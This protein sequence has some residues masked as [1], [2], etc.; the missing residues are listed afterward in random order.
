[1]LSPGGDGRARNVGQLGSG[2]LTTDPDG[3]ADDANA[4]FQIP[5]CIDLHRGVRGI[6][7]GQD[8]LAG[9]GIDDLQVD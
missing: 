5:A 6:V 2:Q 1:M 8:E 4:V 7:A 3:L 9:R